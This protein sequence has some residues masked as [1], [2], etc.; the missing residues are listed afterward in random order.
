MV[1][2]V[3]SRM[4]V[5]TWLRGLA[6]LTTTALMACGQASSASAPQTLVVGQDQA[7]KTFQAKVGDTVR[8][9]LKE[10]FPLPGV[11]LVWNVSSS[12]PEF[13]KLDKVTRDPEVRPRA[14]DVTYTA[15]F[16]AIA[17]GQ[18]NLIAAG[19]RTCEA[20]AKPAC[21]IIDFMIEVLIAT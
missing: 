19:S 16:T 4:S 18:A 1:A 11:S 2:G 13:L 15:D 3:L 8:M 14:G 12:A 20:M 7:G 6:F 5:S 9:T 10:E 21:P 17:A